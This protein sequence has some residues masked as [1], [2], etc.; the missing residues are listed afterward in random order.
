VNQL[1]VFF[2]ADFG[3]NTRRFR[4][5]EKRPIALGL[6]SIDVR[7]R[8]RVNQHIESCGAYFLAQTL[9]IQKIKLSMI[10]AHNIVFWS[11]FPHERCAKSPART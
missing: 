7:E 4:V 6:A 1:C 8:C 11:E 2:V 9:Q 10:E 3:K 5:N